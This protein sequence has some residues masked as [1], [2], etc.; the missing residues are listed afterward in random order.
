MRPLV[1]TPPVAPISR[2]ADFGEFHFGLHADAQKNQIRR[3]LAAVGEF[4]AVAG[5]FC[6]VGVRL[7]I[8]V[9]A[10][11]LVLQMRGHVA[12]EQRQDVRAAFDDRDVDAAMM[13]RLGHL[14]SDETAA[15]DDGVFRFSFVHE[16]RDAI[17]VR[18]VA[19]RENVRQFHAGNRRHDGLRALAQ[20]EFVV[21]HVACRTVRAF[22]ADGFRGA[23][24]GENLVIDVRVDRASATRISPPS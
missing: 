21:S 7:E 5:K 16:L 20:N 24:D 2:P 10:A 15:D 12:V 1:F 22:D 3:E 14:Q 4:D 6:R 18:D 9:V 17:H 23:V 8:K 11:N 19:Q 13:K